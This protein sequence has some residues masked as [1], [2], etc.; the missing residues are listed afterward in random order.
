MG[1]TALCADAAGPVA[2]GVAADKYVSRQHHAAAYH[3]ALAPS[4]SVR[5]PGTPRRPPTRRISLF[6][7]HRFSPLF[8][9]RRAFEYYGN[10][11]ARS[12]PRHP[13]AL[14]LSYT[15]MSSRGLLAAA[16]ACAPRTPFYL[17]QQVNPPTPIRR[18][19]LLV[20]GISRDFSHH[21]A[22]N[23]ESAAGRGSEIGTGVENNF[24]DTGIAEFEEARS[25]TGFGRNDFDF[26]TRTKQIRAE[27]DVSPPQESCEIEISLPR[28]Q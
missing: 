8:H 6:P 11:H 9:P 1:K 18:C 21:E 26:L 24:P 28:N 2:G 5:F 4:I 27:K 17:L 20:P 25:M 7:G 12:P 19:S 15:L 16:A 3:A 10:V 22:G 23:V 14:H 13:D